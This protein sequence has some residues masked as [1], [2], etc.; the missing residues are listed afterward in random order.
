MQSEI[1]CVLSPRELTDLLPHIAPT[2]PVLVRAPPGAGKTALLRSF[3]EGQGLPVRSLEASRLPDPDPLEGLEECRGGYQAPRMTA[4]PRPICILLRGLGATPA[5]GAAGLRQLLEARSLGRFQLP[6][7]SY[8]LAECLPGDRLPEDLGGLLL[9][10]RLEPE[11]LEWLDWARREGL[12]PVVRRHITDHPDQLVAG[13][14]PGALGPRS[15]PRAWHRLS[16]CLG[17]GANPPPGPAIE[18]LARGLLSRAHVEPFLESCRRA[19]YGWEAGRTSTSSGRVE[20][21]LEVTTVRSRRGARERSPG[22][23]PLTASAG[24]RGTW[25]K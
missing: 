15:S 17:H 12:H 4:R 9:S 2:T 6:P 7:G 20:M 10:V 24:G 22:S 11:P 23:A 16:D 21:P 14:S 25:S 19:G 13:V 18:A 8:L 5:P 1:P 3:A